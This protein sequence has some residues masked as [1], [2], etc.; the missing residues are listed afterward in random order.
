MIF[1]RINEKVGTD[2]DA[3]DTMHI[4]DGN[5][6][7]V[8]EG[9]ITLSFRCECSDENCDVRIPI[10]LKEYEAIHTNRDTFIVLPNHQVDLIEKVVEESI[11]Y[12][13][14]KKNHS[15]SEPSDELNATS[16]DN[17]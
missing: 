15:T 16:V 17:S 7:L 1:R 4:E 3:L 14:V 9:D 12:S 5:L 10:S 8:R 13:V 11:A 2:L 6:H